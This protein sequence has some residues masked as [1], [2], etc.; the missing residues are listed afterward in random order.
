MFYSYKKFKTLNKSSGG[1]TLE[2]NYGRVIA[3]FSGLI[4]LLQSDSYKRILGAGSIFLQDFDGVHNLELAYAE[5]GAGGCYQF[6]TANLLTQIWYYDDS[7]INLQSSGFSNPDYTSFVIYD[8]EL[9]FRQPQKGELGF[10]LKNQIYIKK[11]EF[12]TA[13]EFWKKNTRNDIYYDLYFDHRCKLFKNTVLRNDYHRRKSGYSDS[14][15]IKNQIVYNN[16]IV[17]GINSSFCFD[18]NNLNKNSSYQYLFVSKQLFEGCQL[19]AR[20]KVNLQN[21]FDYYVEEKTKISN[22]LNLK[23]TYRHNY[24]L[25]SDTGPLYL[26][27]ES[28]W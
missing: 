20:I 15:R 12:N 13:I 17:I 6:N 21:Q 10:H 22:N 9:S 4:T 19:S 16:N 24:N 7:F 2:T 25:N 5:S 26:K 23:I 14:N 27:M 18:K 8:T 1:I 28:I 3:G 11:S